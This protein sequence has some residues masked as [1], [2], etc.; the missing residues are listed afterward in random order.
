M[1]RG[2]HLVRVM[3]TYQAL[4]AIT[5]LASVGG[6]AGGHNAPIDGVDTGP[7]AYPIDDSTTVTL[8]RSQCYGTCPIYS[9]SITGDGK[10]SY[11]GK[12]YVKVIGAASGQLAA[13]GLQRLV[14]MMMEADYFSLAV[15]DDCTDT[16][17]DKPTVTTSLTWAGQ[18]HTIEDY[19]GNGCAPPVL[20][21]LESEI[22]VVAQSSQ[23]VRCSAGD[24]T[25]EQ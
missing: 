6:C 25:C 22:D 21:T 11:Q 24:R 12:K 4:A 16:V 1:A 9:L 19:H 23:W 20:W 15:P 10:V 17:T 13:S 8:E 7:A 18:T 14:D 2:L 5:V 3:T